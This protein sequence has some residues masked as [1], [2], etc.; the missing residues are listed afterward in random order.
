MSWLQNLRVNVAVRSIERKYERANA[1][2]VD[3]FFEDLLAERPMSDDTLKQMNR[4]YYERALCRAKRSV[5][6]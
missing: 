4:S 2:K 5:R 6:P 1:S 3:T